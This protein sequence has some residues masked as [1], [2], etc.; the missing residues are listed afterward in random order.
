MRVAIGGVWHETNTFAAHP[1][2]LEAFEVHEGAALLE[3]FRGTRT[4]IGG[5][6][7]AAREHGWEVAPALFASATPSGTVRRAAYEDLVGRMVAR[8]A[9]ARPDAVLLDLHGAM[10]VEGIEEVEADEVRRVRARLGRVP[11]GGVLDFH[12][13]IS[14]SLVEEIDILSGYRTYPHVDPYDRGAEV[15]GLIRRMADGLRPAR[16][17]ARPPL[18]TAPQAQKT[19]AGPMAELMALALQEGFLSVTVAGGFPYADVPHAGVS[20]VVTADDRAKAERR[21]KEIAEAAWEARSRF[22]VQNAPPA[23]AVARA[24]REPGPVI[25]VDQA[26]NIG[27]GSPGDG[28]VLLAELLKARARGA[29]VTIA[30]PEGV[31]QAK[32]AGEV[33]EGAVGGKTDRLHGPPVTVRARVER[34]G[35]G[36]FTYK[37]AYMTNRRVTAGT[38]AVLDA[39]GVKIVL[40]ERKVMPFDAEELRVL[41]IEPRECRI[42]V[43]KSALAWKTAYGDIA[44]TVIDCDTPGACTARLETLP[45]RRLRRPIAPL[46]REAAP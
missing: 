28:T 25:L 3:H 41:G 1:T 31:A 46:D 24:L 42:I 21:A 23:D 4:P 9:D 26:D 36:D 35:P 7:D 43:V 33:F 40:R 45:Y 15:A 10:V 44:R 20:V 38:A 29:V 19:D 5:Y 34:I 17:I 12:A 37:G 8:M 2:P 14:D 11:V 30:D 22:A 18:L 16:A 39:D 13:N 6:L 27:G 32:R